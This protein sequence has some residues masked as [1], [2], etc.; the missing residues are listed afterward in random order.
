MACLRIALTSSPQTGG[1]VTKMSY[2]L[3][4]FVGEYH[5]IHTSIGLTGNVCFIIGSLLFM[6]PATKQTAIWFFLAGSTGMLIGNLGNAVAMELD[7]RWRKQRAE[8]K[9]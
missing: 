1:E 6:S 9:T 4:K 8:A 5:W 3:E 7:R 2:L